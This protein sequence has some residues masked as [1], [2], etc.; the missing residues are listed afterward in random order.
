MQ[1][2]LS[3]GMA[4]TEGAVQLEVVYVV[5]ETASNR[6]QDVLK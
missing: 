4:G 6:K 2:F 1:H 3:F 5:Q